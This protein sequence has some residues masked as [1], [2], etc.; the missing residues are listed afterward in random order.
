MK[1]SRSSAIS[2]AL[3]GVGDSRSLASSGRTTSLDPGLSSP[4]TIAERSS[5]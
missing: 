1:P 3:I 4:L 2:A 5:R